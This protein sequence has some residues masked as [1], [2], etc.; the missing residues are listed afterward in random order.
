MTKTQAAAVRMVVIAI[1]ET[2]AATGNA[3]AP[4]GVVF[5]AL[6]TQGCKLSQYQSLET[7]L[8]DLGLITKQGDL[9]FAVPSRARELGFVS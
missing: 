5:A 6:Q 7:S 2:V 1:Y 3:G 4:A 9:L 8:L